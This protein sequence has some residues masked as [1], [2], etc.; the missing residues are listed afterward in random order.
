MPTVFLTGPSVLLIKCFDVGSESSCCTLGRA[1]PHMRT[2]CKGF[3]FTKGPIRRTNRTP[4][5]ASQT[6]QVKKKG[7]YYTQWARLWYYGNPLLTASRARRNWR[8]SE[9]DSWSPTRASNRA[10]RSYDALVETQISGTVGF[11]GVWVAAR[12]SK[13]MEFVSYFIC[14]KREPN[15]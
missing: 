4:E 12:N 15:H 3:N 14:N 2:S 11:R 13:Y 9:P 10:F 6:C 1:P 8:L 7:C 5:S